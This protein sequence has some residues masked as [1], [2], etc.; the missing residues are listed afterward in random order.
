MTT[1]SILYR[2]SKVSIIFTQ[3]GESRQIAPGGLERI[4]FPSELHRGNPS[5]TMGDQVILWHMKFTVYPDHSK[6]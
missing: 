4:N 5:G 2:I 1:E 3:T 6:K